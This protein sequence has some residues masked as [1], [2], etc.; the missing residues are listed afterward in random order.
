MIMLIAKNTLIEGKQKEFTELAGKLVLATRKEVGCVYYFVEKY[1]DMAALEEHRA[2]AHFQN[3]VPQFG[4]L[5][6]KPSEVSVCEVLP[7]TE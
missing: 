1:R 5:R 7:F 2:S 4:P 3:I 6:T